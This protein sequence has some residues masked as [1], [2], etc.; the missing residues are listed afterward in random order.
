VH[1]EGLPIPADRLSH[2]F[3]P[4]Q[5]ARSEPSKL[6]RSVGLGL[7]IVKHIMEAHHGTIDVESSEHAGTTFTV[8]LPRR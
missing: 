6:G 4:L 8:R 7:Y 3:D 5:R 2:I 1:N